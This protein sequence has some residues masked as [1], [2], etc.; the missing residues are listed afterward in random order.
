MSFWSD[1]SPIV[2]GVI[3]VGAIGL[4]I[5]VMALLN[6]PP[7]NPGVDEPTTTERGLQPQ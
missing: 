2:K 3:I 7:F 6:I 5:G 1:A 4:I